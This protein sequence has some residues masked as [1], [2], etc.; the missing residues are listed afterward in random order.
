V[1]CAGGLMTGTHP[2]G[3]RRTAVPKHTRTCTG[4]MPR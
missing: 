3:A 2:R 4:S 1:L